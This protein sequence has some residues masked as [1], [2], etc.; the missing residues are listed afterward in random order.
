MLPVPGP[1]FRGR[2]LGGKLAQTD[3]RQVPN[4]LGLRPGQFGIGFW[5]VHISFTAELGPKPGPEA[6]PGTG[7]N[8]EQP[9]VWPKSA[10]YDERSLA[11]M[12]LLDKTAAAAICLAPYW[13][14]IGALLVLIG[15]GT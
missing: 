11:C 2:V 10:S 13:R 15:L 14:P 5:S 6:R 1:S 12:A 7:S 9:K 8:I 4:R 3:R